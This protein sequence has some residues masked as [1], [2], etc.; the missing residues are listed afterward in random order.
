MSVDQAIGGGGGPD[1]TLNWTTTEQQHPCMTWNGDPVYY[2]IV[3]FGVGPGSG[4]TKSVAH[5]ITGLK[6]VINFDYS[7]LN[8]STGVHV[9]ANASLT[10]GATSGQ[11]VV[12]IDETNISM[13][14][15]SLGI[16]YAGQ[17]I[18]CYLLYTKD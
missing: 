10:N 8:S 9:G 14:S 15:A 7:R 4:T 2:K 18:N 13:G 1:C 12:G 5:N 11:L 16:S 6:E 3:N 17:T